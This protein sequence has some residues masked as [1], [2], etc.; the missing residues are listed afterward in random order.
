MSTEQF[1]R[2]TS[3]LKL[4]KK[5][6]DKFDQVTKS[7]DTVP[8]PRLHPGPRFQEFE[9]RFLVNLPSLIMEKF[10]SI[11]NQNFSSYFYTMVQLL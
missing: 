4:P 9:V 1:K 10:L 7:C 3:A 11:L 2:R 6:Y 8:R 5:I